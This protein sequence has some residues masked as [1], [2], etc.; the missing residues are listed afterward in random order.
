[1]AKR[2]IVHKGYHGCIEVNPADFSLQGKILFLDEEIVYSGETF[3]ELESNFREQ[4]E[5][6]IQQCKDK[7]VPLPF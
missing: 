6:H 3:A 5:K 2:T 7:G 4:V 1:L